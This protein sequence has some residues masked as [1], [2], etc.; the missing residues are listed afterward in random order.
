MLSPSSF[1]RDRPSDPPIK[2]ATS[3]V[4]VLRAMGHGTLQVIVCDGDDRIIARSDDVAVRIR[5]GGVPAPLDTHLQYP[6][7]PFYDL[8]RMTAIVVHKR[9]DDHR[10]IFRAPFVT[11]S[12]EYL[13]HQDYDV[14]YDVAF[15]HVM[16]KIPY[17]VED[18]CSIELIH[19]PFDNPVTHE[20]PDSQVLFGLLAHVAD[21]S[22]PWARVR[23][24]V[25]ARAIGVYWFGLTAH[26]YAE[27]GR[28]R[29]RDM[30]A[31]ER[32]FP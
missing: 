10:T 11:D 16:V 9:G 21:R 12:E 1:H 20:R 30:R 3:S 26:L 4:D 22:R 19:D 18:F 2:S 17:D 27:G 32:D 8:Q 14:L 13:A 25:R 5:K 23:R 28:G 6:L 24:R 29:A 31:F 15:F 7:G